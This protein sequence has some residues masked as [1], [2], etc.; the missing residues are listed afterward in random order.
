MHLCR[1]DHDDLSHFGM[2]AVIF[3]LI[4]PLWLKVEVHVNFIVGTL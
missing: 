1:T 2:E 3:M 4:S